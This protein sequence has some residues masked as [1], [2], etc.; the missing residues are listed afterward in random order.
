MTDADN[1]AME[2]VLGTLRGKE[3]EAFTERLQQ[4]PELMDQVQ[5]WESELMHLHQSTQPLPPLDNTW[6]K[7]EARLNPRTATE[8]TGWQ[9][10]LAN[11]WQWLA[12]SALTLM[13]CLGLWF[14]T[15]QT[16]P[17]APAGYMAVMTSSNGA[18][19]LTAMAPKGE[20]AL[21]LQWDHSIT[22]EANSRLQLWAISK[23][24]AKPRPLGVFE[25]TVA[26][27]LTIGKAE[28]GL[29][30]DAEYLILTKEPAKGA[31]S[32]TPSEI[33]LAKGLCI[34]F[35]PDQKPS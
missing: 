26:N 15:L 18:A 2:Y 3:R 24:D 32:A 5:F 33:V 9:R 11:G 22:V 28:W 19:V 21:W 14:G 16:G 34:Q 20:S 31:P 7:I 13:L 25:Q 12:S 6:G 4:E 10:L 27:Q 30:K 35:N 17:T 8:P 29:I 23:T 1:L